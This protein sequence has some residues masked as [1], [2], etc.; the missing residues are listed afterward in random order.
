MTCN[1][2]KIILLAISILMVSAV[3][4]TPGN[5]IPS[6]NFNLKN[7]ANF[8]E[9]NSSVIN[10]GLN[11]ERRDMNVSND[12]PGHGPGGY[13]SG[14]I[15]VIIYRLDLTVVLGPFIVTAGETLTV[16]IDQHQWGVFTRTNHN[17]IIS[18]WT[19]HN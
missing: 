18:V 15:E 9:N 6:F 12:T 13:G 14:R 8:Q 11:K 2:K 17:T 5:P 10:F 1:L 7:R 4:A 3:F 19:S 16:P